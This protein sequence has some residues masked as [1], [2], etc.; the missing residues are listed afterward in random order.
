MLR[1]GIRTGLYRGALPLEFEL[2]KSLGTSRN[3][4]RAALQH[5]V[6]EGIV[7]RVRG[8]G[9]H[10]VAHRSSS[11]AR[12]LRS[13]RESQPDGVNRSAYRVLEARSILASPPIAAAL[14]LDVGAPVVLV[15][16][17][18][19]LDDEPVAVI[20][21]W[22]A[23]DLVPG[24]LDVD[25]GRDLYGLLEEVLGLEL[26]EAVVMIDAVRADAGTSALLD[27]ECGAPLLYSEAVATLAD[28]RPVAL[29]CSRSRPDRMTM[30]ATRWRAHPRCG[31]VLAV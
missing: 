1:Y 23:S 10:V 3:A 11:D 20:T 15:E 8:T 9:T 16:R 4:L 18:A 30:T 29:L 12:R 25:L 17:V 26:A 2:V 22:L 21:S 13:Y 5:L 24:L 7:S 6:T 28:G 31:D 19:L 27:T 14:E